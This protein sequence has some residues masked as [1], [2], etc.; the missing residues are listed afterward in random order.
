MSYQ[1]E[2]VGRYFFGAL[3]TLC[4]S[5]AI[6]SLMFV[7]I[8]QQRTERLE[9]WVNR[10]GKIRKPEMMFRIRHTIVNFIVSKGYVYQLFTCHEAV[11]RFMNC[12]CRH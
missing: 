3:C 5:K 7:N 10:E 1:Q 6:S 9:R 12:R 2:I 11:G 8:S 4:A